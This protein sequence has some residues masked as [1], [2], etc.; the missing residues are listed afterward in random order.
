MTDE[1]LKVI[2]MNLSWVL[3]PSSN[4][5]PPE[6]GHH[7]HYWAPLSDFSTAPLRHAASFFLFT[8][9]CYLVLVHPGSAIV[10]VTWH[11]AHCLLDICP[12]SALPLDCAPFF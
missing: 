2:R 7:A 8:L 6:W 4:S 3:Y 11:T 5:E 1:V 9:S 12:V 10:P